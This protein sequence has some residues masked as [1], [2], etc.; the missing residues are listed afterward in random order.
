MLYIIILG[1]RFTYFIKEGST[2]DILI[3]VFIKFINYLPITRR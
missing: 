1:A 2:L 3:Y